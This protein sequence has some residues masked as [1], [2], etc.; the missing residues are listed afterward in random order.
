MKDVRLAHAR[1]SSVVLEIT[2]CDN[3][4]SH[5]R[6]CMV[7][8]TSGGEYGS[9][10]YCIECINAAARQASN[11]SDQRSAGRREPTMIDTKD[12]VAGS[13]ASRCWTEGQ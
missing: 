12:A 1:V 10:S 13:A 3:C 5:D 6:M 9:V 11:P 4:G 2:S 8:D 7:V